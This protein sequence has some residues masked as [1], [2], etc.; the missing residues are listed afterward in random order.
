[1]FANNQK[2]PRQFCKEINKVLKRVKDI[3]KQKV[4]NDVL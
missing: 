2:K 3:N 4:K 1:M